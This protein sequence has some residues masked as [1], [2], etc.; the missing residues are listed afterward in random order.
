M[1]TSFVLRMLL[2]PDIQRRAQLEIDTVVGTDRLPSWDDEPNLPYVSAVMKEVMRVAPSAPIGPV[3][4][5]LSPSTFH[6]SQYLYSSIHRNSS[7]CYMRGQL[8]GLSDSQEYNSDSQH[9][10]YPFLIL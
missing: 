7:C 8:Y 3:K 2:H 10:V 4:F 5:Y 9:L 6:V 1:L